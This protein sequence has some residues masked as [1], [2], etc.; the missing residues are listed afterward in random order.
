METCANTFKLL[1]RTI[2]KANH[3]TRGDLTTSKEIN[4]EEKSKNQRN[5]KEKQSARK[6][7]C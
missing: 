1:V 7:N 4:Y 5:K 2:K 3:Q 6:G